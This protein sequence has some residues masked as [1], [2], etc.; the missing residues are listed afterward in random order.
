M[1]PGIGEAPQAVAV[2]QARRP[3]WLQADALEDK[4]DPVPAGRQLAQGSGGPAFA[5]DLGSGENQAGRG[6]LAGPE[7]GQLR[8]V[9][10]QLAGAGGYP[11]QAGGQRQ[12]GQGAPRQLVVGRGEGRGQ[13]AGIEQAQALGLHQQQGAG[14]GRGQRQ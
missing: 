10:A 13:V 9:E 4:A 6:G 3:A 8:Q 1:A 2:L 7:E 14:Q 11:G 5:I 12:G